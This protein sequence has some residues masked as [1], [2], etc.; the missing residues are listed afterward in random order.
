MAFFGRNPRLEWDLLVLT[1]TNLPLFLVCDVG[2]ASFWLKG[3]VYG[4]GPG[5]QSTVSLGVSDIQRRTQNSSWT[6]EPPS[7]EIAGMI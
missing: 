2:M 3:V 5:T 4:L 1:A 7:R 6:P